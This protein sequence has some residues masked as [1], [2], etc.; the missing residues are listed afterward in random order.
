MQAIRETLGRVYS[1][2]NAPALCFQYRDCMKLGEVDGKKI[3]CTVSLLVSSTSCSP[4]S[5][6]LFN[7]TSASISKCFEEECQKEDATIYRFL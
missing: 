2:T 4:D 6:K 3:G 1:F 5:T 7:K